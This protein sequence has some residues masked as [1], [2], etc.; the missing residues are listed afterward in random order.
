[1]EV[2]SGRY[3]MVPVSELV[4]YG[5]NAKEHTNTQIDAVKASMEQLASASSP[6]RPG[7]CRFATRRHI[8]RTSA[9]SGGTGSS[10]T[11]TARSTCS[12]LRG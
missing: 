5:G 2:T 11:T 3:E 4:P 8:S 6:W 9:A 7:P 1:M 10:T 12:T